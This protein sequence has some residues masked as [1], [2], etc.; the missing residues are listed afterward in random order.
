MSEIYAASLDLGSMWIQTA[1]EDGK[2]AI[3]YNM[4]RDAYSQISYDE[5]IEDT[6]KEQNVHYI[7]EGSKLYILGEDA[8]RQCSMAEFVLKEGE[9]PLKRPMRNGVINTSSPKTSLMILRQ[10]MKAC[11]EKGIGPA[12]PGEILYFSVPANP[13]DSNLDNTFHEAMAKQYLTETL[14]YDARSFSESLAVV[15]G[16]NPKMHLSDGSTIPLTGIGWS[17]GAGLQN[18]CLAERGRVIEEFSVAKSG[19]FLDEKVSIMTGEPKTKVIRVK[20][21]KL[22]FNNLD[23]EDP[24]ILALD[25]YYEFLVKYVLEKFAERFSGKKGFLEGSIDMILS[26]GTA[27]IPGFDKKVQ[28]VLKTMDLPFKIHEVRLAGGGDRQK[29]LKTVVKGCLIRA[30]QAVKKAKEGK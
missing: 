25:T 9:E 1:R 2:S 21:N 29:M 12:R 6:L 4:V 27:S 17:A 11:L 20:E 15:Y 30:C 24:I 19:D 16:E 28:K 18:F 13:I 26:G 8:Y 10:L 5:D 7:R 14:Q 3:T 23:L 22:D